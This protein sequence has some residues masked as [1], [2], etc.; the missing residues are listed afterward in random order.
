MTAEEI[1]TS[2]QGS[3]TQ[4][5]EGGQQLPGA[6]YFEIGSEDG[7]PTCEFH[8]DFRCFIVYNNNFFFICGT[9][10]MFTF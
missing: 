1:I 10:L 2:N 4:S 3:V 7:S 6:W 5:V 8:D 9:C